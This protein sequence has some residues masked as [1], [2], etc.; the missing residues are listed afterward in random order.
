MGS[1]RDH[2]R[3]GNP[4][5]RLSDG[6][7]AQ[8]HHGDRIILL[9]KPELVYFSVDMTYFGFPD[10]EGRITRRLCLYARD[11]KSLASTQILP[12]YRTYS[13]SWARLR[14]RKPRLQRRIRNLSK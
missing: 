13:W 14:E 10:P 2:P 3:F 9:R 12:L 4:G 5:S 1:A 7:A 8:P 11:R 6:S